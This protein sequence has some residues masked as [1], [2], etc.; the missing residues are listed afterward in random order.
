MLA[1]P[2][3]AGRP[4]TGVLLM[5]LA[6]ALLAHPAAASLRSFPLANNPSRSGLLSTVDDDHQLLHLKVC[7]AHHPASDTA[8]SRRHYCDFVSVSA[9]LAAARD[10]SVVEVEAGRYIESPIRVLSNNVTLRY[11]TSHGSPQPQQNRS[12][13][14]RLTSDI[15]GQDRG[16]RGRP[17]PRRWIS[18]DRSISLL[19]H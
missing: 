8:N 14:M 11:I 3:W 17:R 13:F 4:G 15:F 18:G 7:Q 12:P 6:L 1:P 10:H 16:R 19:H 2:W 9:A 5:L